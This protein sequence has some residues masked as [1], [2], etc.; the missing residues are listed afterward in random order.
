MTQLDDIVEQ[1]GEY[2]ADSVTFLFHDTFSL[3]AQIDIEQ[4]EIV[5]KTIMPDNTYFAIGFGY[6]MIETDMIIWQAYPGRPEVADL[7]ATE[8]AQ[9]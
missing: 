7:W 9:P 1:N 4:E 6:S 8:F 3:T 5:M 2:F